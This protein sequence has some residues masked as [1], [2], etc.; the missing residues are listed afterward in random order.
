MH[1]TE[2]VRRVESFSSDFVEGATDFD[3][4][5]WR[6]W[7]GGVEKT[8]R[9]GQRRCYERKRGRRGGRVE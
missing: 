1:E 9:S 4:R 5:R 6:L 7:S 2:G 3:G 8:G